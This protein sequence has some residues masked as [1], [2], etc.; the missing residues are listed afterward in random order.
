MTVLQFLLEL[1]DRQAA[2]SVRNRIDF[3][4]ALGMELEDP[5]FHH[6][7][8]TDFHQ[9]LAEEGRADR[10]LDLALEKVRAVGLVRERGRQRTDSTH[11]L[12]AV[13]DLTRLELVTEAMRAAGRGGDGPEHAAQEDRPR[14][15]RR[16][17]L[18][19]GLL[20]LGERPLLPRSALGLAHQPAV[21]VGPVGPLGGDGLAVRGVDVG[22]VEH[23]AVGAAPIPLGAAAVQPGGGADLARRHVDSALLR[24]S[25]VGAHR[26]G[27]LAVAGTQPVRVIELSAAPGSAATGPARPHTCA[28]ARAL[29]G[30][31][32]LPS[33]L[34]L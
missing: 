12:A 2:E 16:G 32:G 8:L 9:R 34:E 33:V 7:V 15:V 5:G 18:L 25:D 23:P 13:R 24:R 29:P 1:S 19:G 3:K 27:V 22:A 4:Y 17:R 30:V 28:R 14:G 26:V 31:P 6:S 21:L 11:V 10:L 20:R